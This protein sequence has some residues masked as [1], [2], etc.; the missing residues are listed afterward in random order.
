[1]KIRKRKYV[2]WLHNKTD[3]RDD[4]WVTLWATNK[5]EAMTRVK[6]KYD[7]YRFYLGNTYTIK[8]ARDR[9]GKGWPF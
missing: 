8:E 3:E 7:S 4:E 5:E 6:E 2:V 9:Y 1:M